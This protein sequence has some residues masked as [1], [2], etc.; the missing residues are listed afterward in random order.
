MNASEIKSELTQ[1]KLPESKRSRL[2]TRRRMM[3]CMAAT[4]AAVY[5][6]MRFIEPNWIGIGLHRVPILPQG[7]V[8]IRIVQLSDLH[9]S[10]DVPLDF[11]DYAIDL[12]LKQKPDIFC[13]TGDFITDHWE[14]WTAYS[15]I[16][17]RLSQAVPTFASTGNH[18]GC[19]WV[20]RFGGYAK[21]TKVIEMLEKANIRVLM[22]ESEE[23]SLPNK[24][25]F[26]LIG[27]GDIWA[28]DFNPMLLNNPKQAGL[29]RVLL[30]HNPD[31]KDQ[32]EH[33]DWDLMLS[34]HTHGGQLTLPWGSTPFA[35]VRDK[36]FV[37]GLHPWK[38]H[39]LHITKGVGSL[40]KMRLNC[41]PE[42]SV[43]E[44][45]SV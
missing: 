30:S 7:S 6:D 36:R 45:V 41:F 12:G 44:L 33:V 34:G 2:F 43:V 15:K 38:N 32:I 31:T 40:R 42:I 24:S 5:T 3:A 9:A 16:L 1:S 10:T 18:D 20:A 4:A 37:R 28:R 25:R 29:P 13:L 27:L 23:V 19:E 8:P 35:P 21:P 11:I 14:E 17:E 39:W 22:N 26:E